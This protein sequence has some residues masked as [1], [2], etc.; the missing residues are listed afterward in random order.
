MRA[1]SVMTPLIAAMLGLTC[2]TDSLARDRVL[3]VVGPWEITGIDPIRAGYV[4]GRMGVAETLVTVDGDGNP[5]PA[6]AESWSVSDDRLVWRFALR[7]AARFHDGTPVTAEAAVAALEKA[8]SGAGVLSRTPIAE[9]TAEGSDVVI[10]TATPFA[11]LPA[12]LAN[13][14]SIVLAPASWNGEGKVA[15]IVGS[16]PYRVTGLTPPLRLDVERFDGWWGGSPKV[17]QARYLSVPRGETRAL[18]AESGEADL[19]FALLPAH[20]D[21]LRRNPRVDVRVV[22]IPRTR[23]LK[24]NAGSVFFDQVEERRALSL[25]L[26]RAGMATAILRNPA[27]AAGQ[28][29]PPSM[30]EWHVHDLPPLRRDTAE[31][32]RLLAAAGWKAGQDG[33]LVSPDGERFSVQLRTFTNWPELPL[34]ATAMQAQLREVGIELDV[35]VGNS[36]EIPAGH[37]DGS[38]QMGLASRN[39]SLVPDPLG[40]LL[41]DYGPDGGEWG[42]MNWSDPA[43]TKTLEALKTTFDPAER[44]PLR[45]RVSE[46]IQT[47]LPVIPIAW[48]ELGVAV[49]KR[50][51]SVTIDP[52]EISYHLADL[53]W[54]DAEAP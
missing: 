53:T 17:G 8:R 54:A 50:L 29:L 35:A 51:G 9:I 46:I 10:R 39:F 24:V 4:F 27:S 30:A 11:P 45:A 13:Y 37:R 48:F 34:M 28:L 14:T 12:F 15:G 1:V 40:T 41:E 49:N 3:Q 18:M 25:T 7:P 26:D 36:S 33:I 52:F 19:A 22:P 42:A 47:E 43:L 32:K 6:L 2:T 5:I 44:A 21:R 23:M 20:M 31:A 16:G 38:L